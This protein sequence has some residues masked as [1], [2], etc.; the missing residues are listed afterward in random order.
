MRDTTKI[1]AGSI[2]W[3]QLRPQYESLPG[4]RSLFSDREGECDP[5]TG[6]FFIASRR[7]EL[8][9]TGKDLPGAEERNQAILRDLE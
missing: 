4:Q 7:R 8:F 5:A 9:D 1:S 6:G 2:L 3:G